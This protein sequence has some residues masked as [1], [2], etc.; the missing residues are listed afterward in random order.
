MFDRSLARSDGM[1]SPAMMS[2]PG[3]IATGSENEVDL[4]LNRFCG[5]A[6]AH[7]GKPMAGRS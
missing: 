6:A 5:F 1:T 3:A 2:V 7:S 4:L